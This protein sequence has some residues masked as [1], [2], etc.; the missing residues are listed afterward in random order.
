MLTSL[1]MSLLM[2]DSVLLARSLLTPHVVHISVPEP[3]KLFD[4]TSSIYPQL[5]K[6]LVKS[7][8]PPATPFSTRLVPRQTPILMLGLSKIFLLVG[9]TVKARRC[10]YRPGTANVY[11]RITANLDGRI[12]CSK[13]ILPTRFTLMKT[14]RLLALLMVILLYLPRLW[15][16][17]IGKMFSFLQLEQPSKPTRTLSK[18]ML[19]M[20]TRVKKR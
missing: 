15:K 14:P 13:S 6:L 3:S 9:T 20:G 18:F 4:T 1:Q 2:F 17:W 8:A 10:V 16:P 7:R 19:P 5:V 12:L 11:K